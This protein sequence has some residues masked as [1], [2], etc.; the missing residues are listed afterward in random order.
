VEGPTVSFERFSKL[1]EGI[2]EV[3]PEPLHDVEG[4]VL[5]RGVR[6]DFMN[7]FWEG[8]PEVKDYAV[9]MDAPTIKLSEKLFTYPTAIEPRDGFDIED[10]A[11]ESISSDL[12][13]SS[14]PS[15]HIFIN[16]EG[17]GELEF[18]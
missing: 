15:R 3:V 17:S 2:F 9:W 14:S 13:I 7:Q 16:G 18:S 1:D 10:T 6:P 5:E 8:G 12:F 4:V 11:F